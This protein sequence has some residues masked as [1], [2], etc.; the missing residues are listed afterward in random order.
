MPN[1]LDP[2]GPWRHVPA[3]GPDAYWIAN[4]EAHVTAYNEYLATNPDRE[5]SEFKKSTARY[6]L[7][8]TQC[9][10]AVARYDRTTANECA[11]VRKARRRSNISLTLLS[12]RTNIS[13][14]R[15]LAY[16]YATIPRP[17]TLAR[18]LEACHTSV[19]ELMAQ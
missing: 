6:N 17:G 1:P 12:V 10:E 4:S 7:V 11:M 2:L 18:I 19:A 8:V 9:A 5:S 15:L 14:T 3:Q 13:H 16:E